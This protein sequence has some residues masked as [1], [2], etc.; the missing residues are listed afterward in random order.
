MTRQK[1][2]TKLNQIIK[3]KQKSTG[4]EKGIY[5]FSIDYAKSQNIMPNWDNKLFCEIYKNKVVSIY[6]NL[7]NENYIGNKRLLTRLQ[8]GEFLPEKLATMKPQHTF[9]EN[10]KELLDKKEKRDK[11]LYEVQ[12]ET[13][14]SMFTCGRC[15][16]KQCTYY[17]LQTRSA[18]EPMT[19]FVTCTNC[20][21]RWKC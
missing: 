15:K 12:Q 14:S 18:D 6:S 11:L 1:I 16:K 21:K 3:N 19:T 13:F 8:E 17:Q 10:W 2:I 7:Q 4:V 5:N 9:P 20:G